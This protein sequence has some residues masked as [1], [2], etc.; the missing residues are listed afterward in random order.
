MFWALLSFIPNISDSRAFL[1]TLLK[2]ECRKKRLYDRFTF[3]FA[4]L[5]VFGN[6]FQ[7]LAEVATF[8][9]EPVEGGAVDFGVGVGEGERRDCGETLC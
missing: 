7:Q 9:A 3:H 2:G 5:A 6:A 4:G 1:T 8:G